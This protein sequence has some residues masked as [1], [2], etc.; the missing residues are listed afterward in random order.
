MGAAFGGRFCPAIALTNGAALV[1]GV[2]RCG[3][4]APLTEVAPNGGGMASGAPLT[5]V[6]PI[7]PGIAEPEGRNA[8]GRG[9]VGGVAAA[10]GGIAAVWTGGALAPVGGTAA[11]EGGGPPAFIASIVAAILAKSAGA[12]GGVPDAG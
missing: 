2:P 11:T 12:I 5:E 10:V 9:V 4:G 6:G 3:N 7:A 8:G 1:G